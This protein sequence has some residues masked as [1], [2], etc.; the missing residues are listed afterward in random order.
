MWKLPGTLYTIE[1][2]VEKV[3]A[4]EVEKE[5]EKVQSCSYSYCGRDCSRCIDSRQRYRIRHLGALCIPINKEE[6]RHQASR[7]VVSL[8]LYALLMLS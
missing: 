6:T 5:L 1:K 2:K 3:V 7:V 8:L 4:K